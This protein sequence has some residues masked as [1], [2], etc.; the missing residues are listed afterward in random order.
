MYRYSRL[1]AVLGCA[2]TLAMVGCST[3]GSGVTPTDE[4]GKF[5]FRIGSKRTELFSTLPTT[6]LPFKKLRPGNKPA[7]TLTYSGGPVLVSSEDV[8]HLLGITRPTAIPN[9]VAKLLKS[10]GKHI[11]GSGYNNIYTQYYMTSGGSNVYITNPRSSSAA[12]GKTTR[13][14]C[15]RTRPT[16]KS[17]LKRSMASLTSVTIPTARTSSP[18]RPATARRALVR[19]YL[20]LSQRRV[21]SGGHLVSYTNLPYMPDAG[22]NCGANFITPPKRRDRRR[23][24][25]DHRRRPRV[26]RVRH[27]SQ[28]AQRLVQ[29]LSTARSATSARGT[30]IQNDPYGKKSYTAQPMFSNASQSCVHSYP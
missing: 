10:Y 27:R 12:S 15:R 3:N 17:R 7:I 22:G 11:G 28:P 25:R 18:P 1:A 26:R 6:W 23:R 4:W 30:N 8:L 13:T 21:T 14:P 20:R 24:R 2:A 29:Q 5:R 16:R 9:K 19:P